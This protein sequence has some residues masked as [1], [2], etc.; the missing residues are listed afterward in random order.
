MLGPGRNIHGQNLL[1]DTKVKNEI[2]QN[3]AKFGLS[4]NDAN[5]LLYITSYTDDKRG[6]SYSYVLQTVSGIPVYNAVTSFYVN[7]RVM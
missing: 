3:P 6:I 7:K 5:Q 2:L 4:Q 1:I